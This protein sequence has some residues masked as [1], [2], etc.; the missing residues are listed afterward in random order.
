MRLPAASHNVFSPKITRS[1]RLLFVAA[2]AAAT[3]VACSEPDPE[4]LESQTATRSAA[5]IDVHPLLD[6]ML[7]PQDAGSAARALAALPQPQSATRL[8][9]RNRH[10]PRQQDVLEVRFY[11]GTAV[12]VYEVAATGAT[13]IKSVTV[14]GAQNEFMGLVVGMPLS[15]ARG[16]LERAGAT[17][18]AADTDTYLLGDRFAPAQVSLAGDADALASFTVSGYLD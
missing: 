18:L 4:L 3:L 11:E 13:F 8:S 9:V 12:E 10:Q 7:D 2:V 15:E 5:V 17:R 16:A 1:T 6:A 14:S